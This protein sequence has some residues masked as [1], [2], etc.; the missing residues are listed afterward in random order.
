[1]VLP[2]RQAGFAR[3]PAPIPVYRWDFTKSLKPDHAG[4]VGDKV[5][6]GTSPAA[7]AALVESEIHG[8]GR[9]VEVIYDPLWWRLSSGV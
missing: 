1:M 3:V 9:K 6:A 2:H 7:H 5:A 4:R 8:S